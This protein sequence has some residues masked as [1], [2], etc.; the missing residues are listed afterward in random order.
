MKTISILGSTGSIGE[1][2]L[3]IVRLHPKIFRVAAL[4]ARTNIQ[5]LEEQAREF[6]PQ[7]VAVYDPK[8]AL[9]LEKKLKPL[10]IKVVMGD[11]GLRTVSTLKAVDQVICAMVGAVGLAPIF[12]AVRSGKSVAVANKEPLVMAG[13][14]LLAEARKHGAE[15]LPVDSEHSAVWQCLEGKP[16]DTVAKLTLTSSGGPFRV[17]KGSLAK[18][19]PEQALRHPKWKIGRA[20]V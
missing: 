1:S 2:T 12:A 16:A 18:V 17:F 19:K 14:L 7:V 10:R 6:R 8:S 11:D 13:R 15:I 5:R 20:H 4:A 9:I 3:K